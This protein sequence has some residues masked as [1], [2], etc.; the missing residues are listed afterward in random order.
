VV[1]IGV[2]ETASFRLTG[3]DAN[4]H[5]FDKGIVIQVIEESRATFG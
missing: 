4:P 1:G 2:L 3:G 5:V